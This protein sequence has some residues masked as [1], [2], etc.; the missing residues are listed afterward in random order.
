MPLVSA[1][2]DQ[3]RLAV[4]VDRVSNLCLQIGDHLL[5]VV[6]FRYAPGLLKSLSDAASS[7]QHHFTIS[8]SDKL[9]FDA[10][11]AAYNREL[12]HLPPKPDRLDNSGKRL[13]HLI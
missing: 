1:T 12:A 4:V 3:P 8:I 6:L 11:T 13:S 2:N 10:A 7:A 9:R 5:N